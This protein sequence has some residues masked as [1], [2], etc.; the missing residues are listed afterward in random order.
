MA[1]AR[2]AGLPYLVTFHAGGHSSRLRNSIR[3]IQWRALR[4]LLVQAERLIGV[5]QYEIDL[6]RRLLNLPDERFAV[7][8]N[9]SD[10]PVPDHPVKIDPERPLLVSIGRLE[11]YKGHQRVIAALPGV[12]EQ[13][14]DLRLLILG[15]GPYESELVRL[16]RQLGVSGQVEIRAIPAG[17]RMRMAETLSSASLVVLLSERESHPVAVIEA[18]ALGRPALVANTSGLHELA[19]RG[20][21]RAIPLDSDNEQVAGAIIGQLRDPLLPPPFQLPTWD[22]C[23]QALL[24]L[25]QETIGA[26]QCAS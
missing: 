25:Y 10:L 7:I 4:P 9:G 19:A 16:A 17:D 18:L 1:A 8:P 12:L 26:K 6:F 13:Y 2:R 21:A 24:S 20:W 14:P 11:R 23:T 3:G 15:S 5:S 22:D